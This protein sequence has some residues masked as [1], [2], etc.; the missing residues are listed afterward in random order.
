MGSS[1]LLWRVPSLTKSTRLHTRSSWAISSST[2]DGFVAATV[3]GA[4]LLRE[5]V[6]GNGS[7]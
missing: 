6:E 4:V 2:R 7:T 5:Y 1:K 3:T